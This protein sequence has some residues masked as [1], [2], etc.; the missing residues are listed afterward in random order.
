V[1]GVEALLIWAATSSCISEA[2]AES[3]AAAAAAWSKDMRFFLK[4]EIRSQGRRRRTCMAPLVFL[5]ML[6]AHDWKP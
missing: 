6:A 5:G 3:A 4:M 2:A 1:D